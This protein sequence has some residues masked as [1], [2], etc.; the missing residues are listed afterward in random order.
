MIGLPLVIAAFA[1]ISEH[2]ADLSVPPL[3]PAADFPG[4][5]LR[6]RAYDDPPLSPALPMRAAEVAGRRLIVGG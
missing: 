5:Y 2:S 4:W 3:A 1:A 6:G